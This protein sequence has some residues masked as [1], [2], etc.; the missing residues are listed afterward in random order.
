MSLAECG[1]GEVLSRLG[2]DREMA[3]TRNAQAGKAA[4][5]GTRRP[6][7]AETPTCRPHPEPGKGAAREPLEQV[8][9]GQMANLDSAKL[10]FGAT[11]GF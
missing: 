1:A 9:H 10:L 8:W 4:C 2:Y 6:Q 7:H 11:Q 5:L 3:Q